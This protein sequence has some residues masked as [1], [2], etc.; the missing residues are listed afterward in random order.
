MPSRSNGVRTSPIKSLPAD[1][2]N[3]IFATWATASRLAGIRKQLSNLQTFLRISGVELHHRDQ[4][5]A[6]CTDIA[7][8]EDR[9]LPELALEGQIEV[10]RIRQ[11]IISLKS[12]RKSDRQKRREAISGTAVE[13]WFHKG[14]ALPRIEATRP[15]LKW[16]VHIYQGWTNVVEAEGRIASFKRRSRCVKRRVENPGSGANTGFARP[17]EDL[18]PEIVCWVRRVSQAEPGSEAVPAR[19][20]EC[21]RYTRIAR[22]NP[23]RRRISENLRLFPGDEGLDLILRVV[24]WLAKFPAH[25]V[26]ES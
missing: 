22:K 20:R 23:A 25:A 1:R 13:R 21:C 7:D 26:I 5:A 24:P 6:L 15:A 17:S 2:V 9:G 16:S 19:R 14:E 18:F 3:H 10:H 12:R 11:N 8:R 4:M